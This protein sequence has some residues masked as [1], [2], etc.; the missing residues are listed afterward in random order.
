MRT[1]SQVCEST[2]ASASQFTLLWTRS[3]C[4]RPPVMVTVVHGP[5][6]LGSFSVRHVVLPFSSVLR[7]LTSGSPPLMLPVFPFHILCQNVLPCEFHS[8]TGVEF[9]PSHV[10]SGSVRSWGSEPGAARRSVIPWMCDHSKVLKFH[11]VISVCFLLI[12]ISWGSSL[13]PHSW[14]SPGPS[15]SV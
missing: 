9:H 11:V 15:A 14:S 5:D 1:V 3:S 12:F 10:F 2:L 13:C 7:R 4:L 8:M 6:D